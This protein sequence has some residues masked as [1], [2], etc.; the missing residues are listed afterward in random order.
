MKRQVILI[1]IITLLIA[2]SLTSCSSAETISVRS[3]DYPHVTELKEA[4]LNV[5]DIDQAIE[6]ETNL[7]LFCGVSL[8]S[9]EAGLEPALVINNYRLP[10]VSTLMGNG[11]YFVGMHYTEFMSGLYFYPYSGSTSIEPLK[12]TDDV[13]VA[14]LPIIGA[15]GV[16]D[17]DC[18]YAVTSWNAYSKDNA[19]CSTVYKLMFPKDTTT[20]PV[21]EKICELSEPAVS[22]TVCCGNIYVS[23]QDSLYEVS[24][25]GDFTKLSVPSA[26]QKLGIN[27][28]VALNNEIFIGTAFGVLRFSPT[29][30]NYSWFPLGDL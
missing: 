28:M 1:A 3:T 7:G 8:S 19:Y 30:K 15:D 4:E 22:A 21:M 18:C 16:P 25:N 6:D 9:S 23:T 13:C 12:L 5:E 26:W 10:S 29:S 20:K 17:R 11:G 24:P 27:S 2:F 14:L